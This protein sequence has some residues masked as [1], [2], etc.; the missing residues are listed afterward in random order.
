VRVHD[1]PL[2]KIHHEVGA[3]DAIVDIVGACVGFY[4]A[5]TEIRLPP[6]NGGAKMAHGVLPVPA[7]GNGLLKGKP[8]YSNGVQ[9]ELLRQQKVAII[10]ALRSAGP[11]PPMTSLHRG[12]G[13]GTADL[14]ATERPPV[15]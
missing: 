12:C 9:S 13:A 2:E 6:L 10:D 11:H 5:G 7:A 15:S 14:E 1:V 3:I 8:T 4:C